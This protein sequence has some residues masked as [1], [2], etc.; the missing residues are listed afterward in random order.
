MGQV[1]STRVTQPK[2]KGTQQMKSKGPT[3]STKTG[4]KM[5]VSNANV[6][7]KQPN[8]TPKMGKKK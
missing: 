5:S 8:A 3:M 4:G 7:I 6:H 2:K 1:K